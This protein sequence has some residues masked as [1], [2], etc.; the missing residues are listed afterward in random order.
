MA[1]QIAQLQADHRCAVQALD[2]L[3]TTLEERSGVVDYILLAEIVASL[4]SQLDLQHRHRE[5]AI[6]EGISACDPSLLT[7]REE[8]RRSHRDLQQLGDDLRLA[9]AAAR[10]G[11][12]PSAEQVSGLCRRYAKAV[13][14]HVDMA[15]EVVLPL[16]DRLLD[17]HDWAVVDWKVDVRSTCRLARRLPA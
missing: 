6:F 8:V 3:R 10:A 14:D 11:R 15:E 17:G 7:L 16:A 5:D 2:L 4:T 9:M 13:R 12:A 1:Q